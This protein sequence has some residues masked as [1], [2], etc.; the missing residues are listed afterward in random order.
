MLK[1]NKNIYILIFLFNTHKNHGSE[2][3][4]YKVYSIF[5]NISFCQAR[6]FSGE[7]PEIQDYWSKTDF[8]HCN[9]YH[10]PS[11]IDCQACAEDAI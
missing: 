5:L 6:L 1:K 10:H 7:V 8:G 9:E 3:T 2:R 4:Q 11:H